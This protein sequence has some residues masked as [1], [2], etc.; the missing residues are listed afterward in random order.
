M[1]A[2]TG[3]FLIDYQPNGHSDTEVNAPSGDIPASLHDLLTNVIIDAITNLIKDLLDVVI[4]IAAPPFDLSLTE[5]RT[6]TPATSPL[7]GIAI[8]ATSR[9]D[10]E[11]L[12]RGLAG[13]YFGVD[14]TPEL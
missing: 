6:A 7:Q 3:D 12:A 8:T 14:S 13:S 11:T 5:Q 1:E 2:N 9:N 10:V 4:A